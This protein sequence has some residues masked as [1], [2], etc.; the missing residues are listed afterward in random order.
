MTAAESVAQPDQ[1]PG[2]P[3]STLSP[4]FARELLRRKV[5]VL[6]LG[7]LALVVI[8]AVAAPLLLPAVADEHAGDLGNVLKGPSGAHLLGTDSLGRDVLQRLMVGTRPTLV[9]ATEAIAVTLLIGVPTGLVAG[10]FGGWIDRSI[11]WVAD[12]LL[13]LPAIVLTLVVVSVFPG[14]TTAAMVTVGVVLSPGLARVVRA[15]TLPVANELYVDAA[16][17]AGMSKTY[18]VGRHVLVRVSGPIVVQASFLFAAGLI[19]QTGLAYLG[20]VGDPPPAPSWGGMVADGLSNIVL[21]PWLIWPPGAAIILTAL[22]FVLLGD[23]V[24]DSAAE[25]WARPPRRPKRRAPSQGGAATDAHRGTTCS[26]SSLLSV[27][28]LSVALTG[29]DGAEVRAVD[30]VSFSISPGETV[31]LIGESGCGKTLT[32]MAIIDL[33]P[34]A[35][36][37]QAGRVIFGG[38]DL[39]QLSDG[40]MNDIRGRQIAVISQDP[41]VSLNPAF[42][43]GGQ[44]AQIV[45]RHTGASRSA[46]R[47]RAIE[48]LGR[49]HLPDPERVARSYPHELSGGMAQRVCIARA[50][51]GEPRLLIADEPTTALDVTVQAGILEL[52][53]ELQEVNGISVLLVTH[54]WGVVADRCDRAIVMYAGQVVEQADLA[55]IFAEPLHPYTRGLLAANPH[56]SMSGGRLPTIPGSVPRPGEWPRA[57]RFAPRCP[58]AT[59]PCVQAPIPLETFDVDRL[60]RCVR[61]DELS[62]QRTNARHTEVTR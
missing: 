17:V 42:R 57:C 26:D 33:L 15:A 11:M 37:V 53:A 61:A 19:V 54:D 46:A 59:A 50:L 7:W 56:K 49:V 10:F 47:A 36:E 1:G 4:S 58:N 60:V 34:A 43:I 5:A 62:R 30:D 9:A 39:T 24:R 41:M 29:S 13:S 6:C 12:L 21:Q 51:A 31:G 16:R 23:A 44:L 28:G 14:N 48:L 35:A 18:I 8:V 3:T 22:A 27:E 45:R 38:R 20:V 40:A 2:T 25:Q 32:A 55:P 52:L